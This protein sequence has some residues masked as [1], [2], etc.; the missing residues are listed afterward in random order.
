[1]FVLLLECETEP[2]LPLLVAST[3][4]G[5]AAE[6]KYAPLGTNGTKLRS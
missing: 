5:N 1:M 2:Y 3:F 4:L 6:F